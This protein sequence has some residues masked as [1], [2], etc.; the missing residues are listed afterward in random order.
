MKND[1]DKMLSKTL[2]KYSFNSTKQNNDF[3]QECQSDR[4]LS[5]NEIVPKVLPK[6]LFE[7]ILTASPVLVSRSQAETKASTANWRA[8]SRV[9]FGGV[10][11]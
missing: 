5:T 1:K 9:N 2:G 11:F 7:P 10:S 6:S 4:S 3:P 8:R